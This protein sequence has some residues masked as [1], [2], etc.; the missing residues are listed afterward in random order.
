MAITD[1][2]KYD[3]EYEDPDD[4]DNTEAEIPEEVVPDDGPSFAA[5]MN[6]FLAVNLL[7]PVLVNLFQALSECLDAQAIQICQLQ[8]LALAQQKAL[9]ALHNMQV[10]NR[11]AIAQALGV[12]DKEIKK[13]AVQV[14]EQKELL[15]PVRIPDGSSNWP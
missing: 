13:L 6:T 9:R 15:Y 7:P 1:W 5:T 14:E 10:G 3:D 8:R 12:L 2:G 4:A 11:N